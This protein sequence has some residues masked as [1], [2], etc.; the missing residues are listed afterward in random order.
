MTTDII[1]SS[2]SLE[3]FIQRENLDSPLV[4][5]EL[6]SGRRFNESINRIVNE[7]EN[8]S[9]E[10]TFDLLLIPIDV[11]PGR[12]IGVQ[13]FTVIEN[14]RRELKGEDLSSHTWRKLQYELSTSRVPFL[15]LDPSVL[16]R[17][18]SHVETWEKRIELDDPTIYSDWTGFTG[19]FLWSVLYLKTTKYMEETNFLDFR[20]HLE[21]NE[22]LRS[23]NENRR[24]GMIHLLSSY[25]CLVEESPNTVTYQ[26]RSKST[27]KTEVISMIEDISKMGYNPFDLLYIESSEQY[28]KDHQTRTK[29]RFGFIMILQLILLGLIVYTCVRENP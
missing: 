21:L 7:I 15:P 9:R 2:E 12:R 6:D 8:G 10:L 14:R 27:V 25:R 17:F 1:N 24:T 11:H 20:S 23:S 5:L 3:R 4:R 26:G 29:S 18:Y 19:S 22:Y 28:Q 16:L 13:L